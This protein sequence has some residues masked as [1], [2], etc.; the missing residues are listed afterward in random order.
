MEKPS[1]LESIPG[2][3]TAQAVATG[4]AATGAAAYAPVGVVLLPVLANALANGR[5]QKRV[6]AAIQQ[7]EQDFGNLQD[8]LKDL[9]DA[10]FKFI[11]EGLVTLTQTVEK[12]K[13]EYL[14]SAIRN[15]ITDN[16]LTHDQA[17]VL[18]RVV[19]DISVDEI[20]FLSNNFTYHVL[21]FPVGSAQQGQMENEKKAHFQDEKWRSLED[22]SHNRF[23]LT[24][25]LS[26]GL[27]IKNGTWVESYKFSP[28]V[29]KLLALLRCH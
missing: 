21:A 4:L 7:L 20:K 22:S 28:V 5:Y 16:D 17:S 29:V 13:L 12:E 2:C 9:T 11:N 8:Q 14:K 23:I 15:G 27:L 25:L 1:G 10:Q 18:S 3:L 26:L 19:R 24:G 6:A